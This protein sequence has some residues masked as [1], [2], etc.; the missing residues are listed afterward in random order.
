MLKKNIEKQQ[1]AINEEIIDTS[2][3]KDEESIG[4]LE[5]KDEGMEEKASALGRA[6]RETSD[7][8]IDEVVEN[9]E[10]SETELKYEELEIAGVTLSDI[11]KIDRMTNGMYIIKLTSGEIQ[12]VSLDG[13]EAS[14]IDHF[15]N[16][17]SHDDV[18]QSDAKP[19]AEIIDLPILN[20]EDLERNL[21]SVFEVEFADPNIGGFWAIPEDI[22][23]L[24]KYRYTFARPHMIKFFDS[25]FGDLKPGEGFNP[26]GPISVNGHTLLVARKETQQAVMDFYYNKREIPKRETK[27]TF[28]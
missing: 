16:R 18:L 24:L 4:T 22:P 19:S 8:I 20:I 14:I 12:E 25:A 7:E 5:Q 15:L 17:Q 2:E 3:Q 9:K 10:E 6:A 27:Q 26:E 11:K 21:G 28:K 1:Q 13:G 23:Q